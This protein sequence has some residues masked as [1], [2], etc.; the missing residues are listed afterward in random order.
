MSVPQPA[1]ALDLM[2]RKAPIRE[3]WK[4]TTLQKLQ[5]ET[6]TGSG[7]FPFPLVKSTLSSIILTRSVR[8]LIGPSV[9][10]L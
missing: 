2:I 10:I 9:G 8:V 7:F 6:Y 3:T 1:L 4:K 5:G